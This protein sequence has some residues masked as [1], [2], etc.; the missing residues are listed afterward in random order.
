MFTKVSGF[1]K[2]VKYCHHIRYNDKYAVYVKKNKCIV[3][4]LPLDK[5]R[6]LAKTI[7][8]YL[9]ADKYNIFEVEITVRNASSL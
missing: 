3:G 7:F 4:H 6:N 9:R 1:Q 8:Y 2:L 5:S